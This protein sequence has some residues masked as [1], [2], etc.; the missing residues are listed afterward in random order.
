MKLLQFNLSVVKLGGRNTNFSIISNFPLMYTI[1]C[2][3]IMQVEIAL[4]YDLLLHLP[5]Y[6]F[7]NI[8]LLLVDI[9]SVHYYAISLRLIKAVYFIL[10]IKGSFQTI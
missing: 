9:I 4:D 8:I 6:E 7:N 2:M 1:H 5:L 10:Y 3:F